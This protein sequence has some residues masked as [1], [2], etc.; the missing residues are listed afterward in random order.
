[1]SATRDA[2]LGQ[3]VGGCGYCEAVLDVSLGET[4]LVDL[5]GSSEDQNG[6][7]FHVNVGATAPG[8]KP[9]CD[10]RTSLQCKLDTRRVG[11]LAAVVTFKL[12]PLRQ[13]E[14]VAREGPLE[15]DSPDAGLGRGTPA[16]AFAIYWWATSCVS[17]RW[18]WSGPGHHSTADAVLPAAG[19]D[20]GSLQRALVALWTGWTLALGATVAERPA[21][22]PVRVL[23]CAR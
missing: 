8:C 2:P 15:R 7:R 11:R 13:P 9:G 19:V 3:R 20:Q 12:A 23:L 1:M 16:A 6:V 22:W 17:A 21:A 5:G 14:V 4:V 10:G 18:V